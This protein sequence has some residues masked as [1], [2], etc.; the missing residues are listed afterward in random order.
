VATVLT[1]TKEHWLAGTARGI[2]APDGRFWTVHRHAGVLSCVV[3]A[4]TEALPTEHYKWR[5][6]GW[7]RGRLAVSRIASA[8]RVGEDPTPAGAT[9]LSHEVA[10][11]TVPPTGNVHLV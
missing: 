8:I 7:G 9:L 10:Q 3:E 2:E 6:Q 1:V 5:V 11:P 4:S